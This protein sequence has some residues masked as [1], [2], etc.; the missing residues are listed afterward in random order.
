[1]NED[2]TVRD[3]ATAHATGTVTSVIRDNTYIIYAINNLLYKINES[4]IITNAGD[5]IKYGSI[6]R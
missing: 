4:G 6:V 3:S 2:L 1:M 5:T